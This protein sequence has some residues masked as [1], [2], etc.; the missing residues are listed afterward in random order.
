MKDMLL[1]L[2]PKLNPHPNL[3]EAAD[4]LE[5][6]EKELMSKLNQAMP[7]LHMDGVLSEDNLG[8]IEEEDVDEADDIGE[9][10]DYDM[11]DEE[12]SL[13]RSVSQ[14]TTRGEATQPDEDIQNDDRV[15]VTAPRKAQCPEDDDF[16]AALD[17][18]VAENINE[19][20]KEKPPAVDISIPWQVKV[21]LKKPTDGTD[22]NCLG[23][24]L[25]GELGGALA[26]AEA[27]ATTTMASSPPSGEG[28]T[29]MAFFLMTRKGNKA[30]F[31]NLAVPTDSELAQN[32]RN[33]ELAERVEKERVKK[34]TLDFN[35]RQ[36]E[37]EFQDQFQA[38]NRP[39]VHNVNRERRGRFQHPKGVPDAELI[40]G[41]VRKNR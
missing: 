40:F 35:E 41:G 17:R 10:E 6:L 26:V 3:Q 31:K 1:S 25:G 11:M 22:K 12:R 15:V 24:A 5:N 28:E 13:S 16:M 20:G 14:L 8:C 19:R 9:M 38:V 27:S 37:E 33:R 34:L 4:A 30:Q 21:S 36:E 7:D 39:A 2:R 23:D 18:M 29:T 32:L